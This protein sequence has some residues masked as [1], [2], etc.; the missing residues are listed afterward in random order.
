MRIALVQCA[1]DSD[2]AANLARGMEAVRDAARRGAKLVCFPELSFDLFHPERPSG[3]RPRE[4]AEPIPGAITGALCALARELQLVIVPNLYELDGAETY[5]TSPVIDADGRLLGAQRMVHIPDYEGFHERSYY[6]PGDLGIPVFPTAVGRVGVAIC[7]DRHY[8]EVMRALALRGADLVLVPQAGAV[9]EWPDGLL[10]AEM[11]VAAF[12]NGFFVALCNRVGRAGR[13]E[14]AGGSFICDPDGRVIARAS[15]SQEALLIGDID[16][17][18]IPGSAARTRFLP[19]RRP[20]LYTS[21]WTAAPVPPRA[22]EPGRDADVELR[23][24][25]EEMLRPILA[26]SDR[27]LPGQERMVAPNAVSIAQAHFTE[28]AWFRGI[29]ADG[30]PVGFVMLYDDPSTGSYFL[31]RLMISGP[32][33]GK[34]YGRRAMQQVI[35]YVRGRP[36]AAELKASYVPVPGGPWPFYRALGFTPTGETDGGEI[37]IRLAL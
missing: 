33:Q 21:W 32:H 9:D 30:T 23:V 2:R 34:G 20:E 10:E 6:T 37:V 14:F 8:P 36:G 22:D 16:L 26:L 1:P 17:A 18:Q 4:L 13:L 27:M 28:K 25:T 7:Y 31:W 5:D 29:Y 3:G 15:S 24:L 12:Q 11:R 35:E 19:D